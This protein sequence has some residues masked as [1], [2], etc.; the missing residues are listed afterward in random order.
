MWPIGEH[1]AR[2]LAQALEKVSLSSLWEAQIEMLSDESSQL[3]DRRWRKAHR[4]LEIVLSCL[5]L[6]SR[7]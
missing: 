6:V 7:V 3:L 2:D 4:F 1:R 5:C